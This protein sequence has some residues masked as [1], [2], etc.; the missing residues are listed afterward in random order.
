M[1]RHALFFAFAAAVP[2]MAAAAPARGA[3]HHRCAADAAEVVARGAEVVVT[4][5][6]RSPR[7]DGR[8]I[9]GDVVVACHRPTGSRTRLDERGAAD[10][11]DGFLDRVRVAGP[12]VVYAIGSRSA[13][14]SCSGSHRIERRNLRPPARAPLVTTGCSGGGAIT[15]LLIDRA[16]RT[17]FICFRSSNTAGEA[18][19]LAEVRAID[20][21]GRR[22]LDRTTDHERRIAAGSLRLTRGRLS[23]TTA[24]ERRS[25][26]LRAARSG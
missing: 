13:C 5:R 14:S 21:S 8:P 19:E 6:P 18:G 16:G 9:Y 3:S 10:D 2:L 17:A 4:A 22:L 1:G 15:D 26:Q 23:W 7:S 20:R 24:G 12:Y 11:P 25:A